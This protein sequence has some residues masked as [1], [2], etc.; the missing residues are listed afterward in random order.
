[1]DQQKMARMTALSEDEAISALSQSDI[2]MVL[3]NPNLDDNPIVY[4]SRGFERMT[5]YAGPAALGRNCRFLQ[6]KGSDPDAVAKLRK[7]IENRED[8]AV[9]LVNYRANGETFHNRLLVSPILNS[10][11]ELTFFLGVQKEMT[12][13]DLAKDPLGSDEALREIQHR[14]KNHLAMIVG[15]IR[16]QRRQA[17]DTEAFNALARR[18]ESLQLLYEEM[19]G[20]SGTSNSDTIS[21]GSYLSRVGTAIAHLDGRA[22]IRV[23]I[24]VDEMDV[25]VDMAVRLGLVVSEVMT[26]AFQHAFEGRDAGILD[27]RVNRLSSGAVR[28]M[29]SD[30]GVGLP[31]DVEWPD[32]NS[33]GG[34]I[35]LGLI[36]GLNATLDV[37]RGAAGTIVT[38]DV[39]A[40]T[41]MD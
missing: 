40:A 13:K 33:L 35:V 27:L 18:V 28:A 4:V 41:D 15:L 6:G 2:A 39:P 22:G 25:P 37:T 10:E 31:D 1:M 19:T 11:G 34:R 23:N 5:G 21:L 7:G 14:I 20:R 12:A 29:V 26:N 32:I 38:L 30:D 24:D 9:D 36:D 17:S 8:V 3:T 16:M